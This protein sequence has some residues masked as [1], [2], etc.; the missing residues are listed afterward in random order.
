MQGA[1]HGLGPPRVAL[2]RGAGRRP[3]SDSP[4]ACAVQE[5]LAPILHTAQAYR[6]KC[7]PAFG[8]CAVSAASQSHAEK[9]SKFRFR[10]GC[11]FE[12]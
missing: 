10:T 6:T 2:P 5:G 8:M 11:I 9:T 4:P 7:S 12:W 1:G 3:S